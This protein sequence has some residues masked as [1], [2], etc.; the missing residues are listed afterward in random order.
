MLLFCRTT[1]TC[2][3]LVVVLDITKREQWESKVLSQ[4]IN[5]YVF[6]VANTKKSD[7]LGVH[8]NAAIVQRWAIAAEL[9]IGFSIADQRTD[10]KQIC[11]DAVDFLEKEGR[12]D[13]TVILKLRSAYAS[14][15]F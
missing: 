2:C 4:A 15:P 3:S 8:E 12:V 10:V 9:G 7:A 5:D 6:Y 11:K 1:Q 13:P 14:S